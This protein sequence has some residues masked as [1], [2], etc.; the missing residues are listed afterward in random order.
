M[1]D[2]LPA[3]VWMTDAELA[4]TFVQ[5][6]LIAHL[7]VSSRTLV[8][9][10]LPELLAREDRDLP[11][12]G[13]HHTALAGHETSL[14]IELRGT[15][16]SARIAPLRDASDRVV[17]CVGV[18]QQIGWL[19]DDDGTQRERDQRLRGAMDSN[20]IGI[21]FGNEEG[22]IT[23]ANDAFLQLAGY[24]REDLVADGISWPALTPVESHQRQMQAL[25]EIQNVGRCRPFELSLICR[26][27]QRAPVMVGGARLSADR[28]EAVAFVLD[29]SEHSRAL[30]GARGELA[31]ADALADAAS[32]E[33][34]MPALIE[35]CTGP[36][37]WRALAL[38]TTAATG[39][40]SLVA[41]SG[42]PADGGA[43]LDEL[44][45]HT[46]RA[47]APRWSEA[48]QT[49]AAPLRVKG[50]CHGVLVL[51]GR[52]IGACH[53]DVLDTCSRIAG[54]IARFI[55]RQR[56]LPR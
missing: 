1:F 4:L 49:F 15:L 5:G 41:A 51:V 20:M 28:P 33:D 13:A 16:Y 31:C 55:A 54:R 47:R 21:V 27:G 10:R 36:L 2:S 34:A 40:L 26:N 52:P 30:T 32:L 14:R 50:H 25:A 56:R 37:E 35:A 22:Q 8:G 19:P 6:P 7:R 46:R 43:P 39:R 29:I 38:W 42:L 9:R 53:P 23:D 24:T 44:A 11:F 3:S 48:G 12:I 17:G 18:C 45:S